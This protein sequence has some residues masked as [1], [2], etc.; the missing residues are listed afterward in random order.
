MIEARDVAT[1]DVAPNYGSL[2]T[3]NDESEVRPTILA[4]YLWMERWLA[5]QGIPRHAD[6]TATEYEQRV[7]A[8]SAAPA[9]PVRALTALFQLA[10][11][12]TREL[13]GP[14]KGVALDS[15]RAIGA[16]EQ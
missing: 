9:Q 1:P 6:E 2:P 4:C 8:Q 3:P 11:F 5:H 12:S 15:V 14:M 16:G 13:T 10:G 7:L